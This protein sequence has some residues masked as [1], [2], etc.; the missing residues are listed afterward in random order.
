[1]SSEEASRIARAVQRMKHSKRA[2]QIALPTAAALGAGAAI[3][4]GA[5]PGSDGTITGCYDSK[6][7]NGVPQALF[8]GDASEPPGG[9]RVID[10]SLP[11]TVTPAAGGPAIPNMDA[12][13]EPGETQITWNQKGPAGPPGEPGKEGKLGGSG[14]AGSQ[15]SPGGQGAPGTPL[16]GGT[17]FGVSGGGSTFLKLDGI[18]GGATEKDHKNEI[19]IGGFSVSAQGA[20]G[21]ASSGAGAGKVSVQSFSI[22]KSLDKSSPLL[23][24]AAATGQHFKEAVLSFAHK[25]GG[26]EQTY[27]KFDFQNVLISSVQDGNSGGGTPQEQVTFSFQK[28]DEAFIEPN[29]KTGAT[30]GFDLST[31]LKL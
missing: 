31:N 14:P 17:T 3:A 19:P 25:L 11:H 28:V 20:I 10:P 6:T 22:T 15:G 21:S 7:E 2:V 13:C 29:G 5:I 30:V 4:A 26:K 18:A 23:F 9:L 1:M 8:F 24:Q 12:V 16:I 27:L